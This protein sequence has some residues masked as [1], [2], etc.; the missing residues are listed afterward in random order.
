MVD[1]VL[2]SLG[3][4]DVISHDDRSTCRRTQAIGSGLWITSNAEFRH[5]IHV[6]VSTM[7]VQMAFHSFSR[8]RFDGR[9]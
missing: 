3:N 2:Q 5:Y 4:H 8:G 7:C 6:I 1:Q 9:I